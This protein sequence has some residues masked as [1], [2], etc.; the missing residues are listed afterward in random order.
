MP[1]LLGLSRR[2][3]ALLHRQISTTHASASHLVQISQRSIC[4]DLVVIHSPP[5]ALFF[6]PKS[7]ITH[8]QKLSSR[9]SCNTLEFNISRCDLNPFRQEALQ[10]GCKH[11]FISISSQKQQ[12]KSLCHFKMFLSSKLEYPLDSRLS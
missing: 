10:T 6:S 11:S 4:I 1:P 3:C 7:H 8:K 2:K 12:T 5:F 9:L